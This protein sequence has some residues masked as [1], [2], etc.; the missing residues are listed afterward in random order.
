MNQS[1]PLN[2]RSEDI[3][4]FAVVIPEL[5]FCNVQVKI[6]F[7]DLIERPD[8]ATLQNLPEALDCISMWSAPTTC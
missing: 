3:G 6:L 2:R 5:K 4:V 7:T 1:A 8:Y